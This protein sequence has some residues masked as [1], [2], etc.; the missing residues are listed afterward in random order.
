MVFCVYTVWVYLCIVAMYSKHTT[1]PCICSCARLC[2]HVRVCIQMCNSAH[3]CLCAQYVK[4]H[5]GQPQAKKTLLKTLLVCCLN[6]EGILVKIK[7]A[8]V[9]T[10]Q[11]KTL[12]K[13]HFAPFDQ[14]H[15]CHTHTHTHT[16]VH[17]HTPGR[18]ATCVY[19]AMWLKLRHIQWRQLTFHTFI[20]LSSHWYCLR[21]CGTERA[22]IIHYKG[23]NHSLALCSLYLSFPD[24]TNKHYFVFAICFH[25]QL[26]AHEL[27]PEIVILF[28]LKH[29]IHK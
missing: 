1:Y 11:S 17:T 19:L 13:E 5:E 12:S 9:S 28:H 7:K 3:V 14:S 29:G 15:W 6:M 22:E 4:Q 27:L 18:T 2:F 20:N 8:F 25:K 24:K 26:C 16:Q 10:T 21:C 23:S